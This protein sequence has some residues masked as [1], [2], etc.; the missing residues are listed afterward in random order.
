MI[1]F[2]I[3]PG[4][5]RRIVTFSYDDGSVQDVR[6]IEM[7]NKYGV[8][9]TFHLNGRNYI[10]KSDEE[11]QRIANIYSGHEI[12]CHTVHH[13]WPANMP[14]VSIVNET[15]EDRRILEKLAGYPVYGMSYPSGSYSD[16]A[17][18]VMRACGIVYSRTTIP[19]KNFALPENF[20]VWHPTCHHRDAMPLL[21]EFT[22]N[23]DSEWKRPLFYIWGHSHELR[24]E[25]NWDYMEKIVSTLAGSDKIWYATS[26]EI[27][28]YITAQRMLRVSVDEKIL[29][30]PTSTDVWVEKDKKDIIC[31]PAGK[32]V[33]I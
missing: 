14:N 32:T 29:Y 5:K 28:E 1:Q 12:S 31:I 9:G 19:N 10:G 8:K 2:N 22:D 21:P 18:E 33:V 7:F 25:E 15:L 3:Y 20:M 11:L 30:N 13:G 17:V 4:G 27:Y 26:M 6:L 23:L 16:R 24:T